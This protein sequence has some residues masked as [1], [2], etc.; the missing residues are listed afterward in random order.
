[1]KYQKNESGKYIFTTSSGE[2]SIIC[3]VISTACDHVPERA[4]HSR[5]GY[6]FDEVQ[7]LLEYIQEKVEKSLPEIKVSENDFYIIWQ[8]FNEVCH[9]L[10][11][12]DY[13]NSTGTSKEVLLQMFEQWRSFEDIINSRQ[14]T[15]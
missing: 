4:F 1:M 14:Q 9:G 10:R 11:I 2:L 13:K 7:N 3:K 15:L 5:M 8:S 12:E 6:Y